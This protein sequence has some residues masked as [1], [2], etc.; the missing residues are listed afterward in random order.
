MKSVICQL[1]IL[2]LGVLFTGTTCKAD[3]SNFRI[4]EPAS[5][6]GLHQEFDVVVRGQTPQTFD[7]G[8]GVG[9]PQ[10]APFDPNVGSY[11]GGGEIY[12]GQ[13]IQPGYDP[14]MTSPYAGAMGDPYAGQFGYG[15]VGPQPV[16]LGWTTHY[17]FA[18]IGSAGLETG[19]AQG[20]LNMFEYALRWDYVTQAPT[21]WTWK[22]SPEF[23]YTEMNFKGIETSPLAAAVANPAQRPMIADNYYR[24]A[25]RFET[26]SPQM[27]MM[28]WRL[29]FTP[30]IASDFQRNINSQ[31][32]NFDAD[33][34]A[35]TR[36]SPN[37]MLVLG[38]LYWDR[39]EDHIL[40]HVGVVWTPNE[41]WEIRATYPKARAD[42]FIGTPFGIATWLYAGAEYDIQ[43]WQAGEISGASP[44]LQTEE[45][46][47]FAGLRW[48]TACWQS[49][50]DFGYV[51]DREYSVHGMSTVAPLDP[52]E[53]F[54][55][56]YGINF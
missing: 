37:M 9:S 1:S 54:M 7:Y 22:F 38:A 14:F 35:L 39:A 17:D 44:Q 40:P 48:E 18:W 51:F 8:P 55:I 20:K 16:R 26:T 33:I 11:P 45:W 52:G 27:G 2:V 29:G 19:T 31:A 43:S 53:A 46:R 5:Y 42:V 24:F 34:T 47:T 12:G 15:V 25:Y 21:G 6:F 3:N 49:Y 32:W 23:D 30:A 41:F 4:S 13:P 36:I 50:L 28:S 56:R 10:V